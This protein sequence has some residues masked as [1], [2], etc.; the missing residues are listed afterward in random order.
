MNNK[1]LERSF[2]MNIKV[3]KSMENGNDLK[4]VQDFTSNKM[5]ENDISVSF[6]VYIVYIDLSS[7]K[8]FTLLFR[9]D[10][11]DINNC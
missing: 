8:I 9:S 3:T 5:P 4:F 10:H 1:K 7:K 11:D 2:G 6:P